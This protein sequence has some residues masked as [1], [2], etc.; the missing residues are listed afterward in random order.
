L[1]KVSIIIPVYNGS[2]HIAR[3][4]KSI[5]NQSLREIEVI[6]VDDNSNDN[7]SEIVDKIKSNDSRIKFFK[8]DTNLGAGIS[9]NFGLS[10]ARG[11]FVFF[12]D[13]DDMLDINGLND[14]YYQID[15]EQADIGFLNYS[16]VLNKSQSTQHKLTQLYYNQSTNK[17]NNI[18][19]Q[20]NVF[21]FYNWVPWN[22]I[23]RREYLLNLELKYQNIKSANDLYFG[24]VS[25]LK[26][27]KMI[28]IKSKNSMYYYY[29]NK[30]E[31]Q[32]SSL[33]RANY[34]NFNLAMKEVK[35]N[36]CSEEIN[37][38]CK[39]YNSC[40][41]TNYFYYKRRS[42][43][44]EYSERKM[45]A[46]FMDSLIANEENRVEFLNRSDLM[47]YTRLAE[48]LINDN[49]LTPKENE[50]YDLDENL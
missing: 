1:I 11:K 20:K 25:V 32:I 26:A 5:L 4:L 16:L 31:F 19:V 50:K 34:E 3:L 13:A 39:S 7:T 14:V 12:A 18:L 6:V 42:I 30:N 36:L 35:K 8:N 23:Y 24:I 33:Y 47:N 44:Y 17:V 15:N 22:R 38:I 41:L 43:G 10:K 40:I 45:L 46:V 9:R 37:I 28:Y 49:E 48:S 27:K 21:Q 29:N 2:D